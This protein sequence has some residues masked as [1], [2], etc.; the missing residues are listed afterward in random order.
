VGHVVWILGVSAHPAR[1]CL[2]VRKQ[3][4]VITAPSSSVGLR[5]GVDR[6]GML[7]T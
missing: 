2:M 3:L 7:T 6:G 1:E 4:R 5:F